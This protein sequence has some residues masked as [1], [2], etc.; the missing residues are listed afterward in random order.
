MTTPPSSLQIPAS[1]ATVTVH[2][3]DTTL[4]MYCKTTPFYKPVL[5]G[6]EHANFPTFAFL[7]EN[8]AKSQKVVFDLG[9]RT[10]YWNYT[11][12]TL[13]LIRASSAGMRCE[14]GMDEILGEKGIALNSIDA[15]VWSHGHFDHLGDCSKW[16]AEVKIV[17][18]EGFKK[19]M[20]PGYP[21]NPKSLILESD[22]A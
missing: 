14:K 20:L 7:I 13:G 17:V 5:P 11:P 1:E 3:I 21:A 19:A 12:V 6:M 16:P 15:I 2:A 4:N 9:G 10:D 18:G 22:Y 8:G